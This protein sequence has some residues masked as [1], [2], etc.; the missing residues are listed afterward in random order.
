MDDAKA[1]LSELDSVECEDSA[2]E[3]A[4]CKAEDIDADAL[5][6]ERD[7][8]SPDKAPLLVLPP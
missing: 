5:L 8:E 3:M 4:V 1:E 7:W 6:D 2:L